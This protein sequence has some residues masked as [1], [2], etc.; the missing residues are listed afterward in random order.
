MR[1]ADAETLLKSFPSFTP[2][3]FSMSLKLGQPPRM[4]G[5]EHPSVSSAQSACHEYSLGSAEA[6]APVALEK[7][8]AMLDAA[9]G[10]GAGTGVG[11]GAGAGLAAARTASE[12]ATR[13]GGRA[14]MMATTSKD[15]H[16]RTLGRP[17]WPR[18]FLASYMAR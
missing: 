14:S 6:T 2:I 5:R 4:A 11:A 17:S 16:S 9:C 1:S 12:S 13:E 15:R 18:A 7:T 10:A 8:D 3:F